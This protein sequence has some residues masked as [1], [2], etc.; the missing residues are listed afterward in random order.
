MKNTKYH[1]RGEGK[2]HKT[3]SKEHSVNE[4]TT[5][6]WIAAYIKKA[7]LKSRITDKHGEIILSA[8]F[9]DPHL[10]GYLRNTRSLSSLV[11]CL[12]NELG[13]LPTAY[14]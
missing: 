9:T 12:T 1:D 14:N 11:K 3:I 8:L 13:I 5:H 7:L 10:C 4:R 6:R 2:T